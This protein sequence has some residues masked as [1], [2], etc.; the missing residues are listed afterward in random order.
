MAS[1]ERDIRS[2]R[3]FGGTVSEPKSGIAIKLLP[4]RAMRSE[5]EMFDKWIEQYR[6]DNRDDPLLFEVWLAHAL[7]EDKNARN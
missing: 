2:H 7:M 6:K 3:T 5:R 1:G 4:Y